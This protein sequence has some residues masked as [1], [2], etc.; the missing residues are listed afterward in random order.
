M[1]AARTMMGPY[2]TP[3]ERPDEEVV[4]EPGY[5]DDRILAV[6]FLL[7]GGARVAIAFAVGEGFGTEATIALFMVAVGVGLL[8]RRS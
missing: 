1:P 4:E 2:R 3:P 5:D 8:L 6:V 7:I